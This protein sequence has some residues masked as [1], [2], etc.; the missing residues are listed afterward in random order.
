MR[1]RRVGT[2][3]SGAGLVLAMASAS[4]AALIIADY[5]DLTA[6]T[7]QGKSGGTGFSG[8][9]SGS[10]NPAV[11]GGDLTSTLYNVPQS[12]TAQSI[13]GGNAGLRQNYRTFSTNPVGTVWFSFLS[14]T[15]VSTDAAGI[16]FNAPTAS[17]YSDTGTIYAYFSG[18]TLNYQFGNGAQTATSQTT[19]GNVALVVGRM[20]I[21]TG[22]AADSVSLWVNPDLIANSDINAYTPVY[23]SSSVDFTDSLDY[24][25]V[26]AAKMAGATTGSGGVSD[27]FRIS[28]G[29]GSSS[30]A[31]S[32]VTGVPEPGTV[33]LSLL[34]LA[35]LGMRRRHRA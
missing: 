26:V 11:I 5:N 6:T 32:D 17:P 4:Q 9:W 31:Y 2:V 15:D 13:R 35:G 20:T 28:D 21:N 7:I 12:G 23:S 10:A 24:L 29:G 19:L 8:S 34:G 30:V 22:G 14:R 27:N 1:N 25:G 3:L 33:A 16:S 18:T